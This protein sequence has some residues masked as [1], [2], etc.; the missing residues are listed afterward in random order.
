MKINQAVKD[1]Y[2]IVDIGNTHTVIGVFFG[3]KI[4]QQCLRIRT[5]KN[6]TADELYSLVCLYLKTKWAIDIKDVKKILI[7]SVVPQLKNLW[8]SVFLDCFLVSY[9]LPWSF[10]TSRLVPSQVGDDRFVN[11]EALVDKV[12]K[13]FIVIDAGTATTFDVVKYQNHSHCYFGGVIAPGLSISMDSL[14]N[15]ASRLRD[16]HT[17]G[18]T[19]DQVKV[20]GQN[21][22]QALRSGYLHGYACMIDGMINRIVSE[23]KW[24]K[25]FELYFTGGL[26]EQ[27][28]QFCDLEYIVDNLLTLK[29]IKK[30]FDKQSSL[31]QAEQKT[32]INISVKQLSD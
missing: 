5:E 27:I 2:L 12:N 20:V 6:L 24:G 28:A 18:F 31:K 16:I 10:S 19:K 8:F 15:S 23:Q 29:G 7:A 21:T 11:I 17:G 1:I 25:D 14:L 32:S 3:G 26:A 13:N 9:K 22:D 4:D 30:I